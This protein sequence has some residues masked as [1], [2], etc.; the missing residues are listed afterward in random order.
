MDG[1]SFPFHTLFHTPF[2]KWLMD[3]AMDGW[4]REFCL[5]DQLGGLKVT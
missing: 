2:V 1:Y 3:M 4:M 5:L